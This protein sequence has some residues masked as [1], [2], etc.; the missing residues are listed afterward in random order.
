MNKHHKPSKDNNYSKIVDLWIYQSEL[1]WR[2]VYS[3]PFVAIAILA[4]WYALMSNEQLILSQSLLIA[5]ILIMLVQMLILY[6]M[7][8]YLNAFKK[9]AKKQNHLPE[10]DNALFGLTGYRIG[11]SVP[12]ILIG[13]F[14]FI[15]FLFPRI[16]EIDN[17]EE[18]NVA[19]TEIKKDSLEN[20]FSN[21]K[22]KTN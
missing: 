15:L 1:F 12:V 13:L 4:G 8:Q 11:T 20:S 19:P 9:E 2:T 16:E 7:S 18:K 17:Y 22:E 14:L 21:E 10:V 5:G 6:R 3:V